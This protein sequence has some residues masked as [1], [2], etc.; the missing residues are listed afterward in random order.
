MSLNIAFEK[1][2]SM[3]ANLLWQGTQIANKNIPYRVFKP[4]WATTPLPK[5]YERS[6]PPL[7]FPRETDS[8][9]PKCVIETREKVLA[10]EM[11]LHKMV[12]EHPGEIKQRFKEVQNEIHIEKECPKHG[13]F[14][15]IMSL[16]SSF[17]KRIETLFPGRDISIQDSLHQ[18]G[19]SSIQYGRGAVLTIDLTNRCNMMCDPCFMDAN[20]VGYVHELSLEEIKKVLWSAANAHNPKRQSSVQFSGGEPT[21]SPYFIE[22]IRYAKEL[23]FFSVQAA[24]N[25][26]RFAQDKEF[27][28][29][30]AQAGLRFAYLQFDGTSPEQATGRGVGNLLEVK[31]K[32]IKNLAEF[33]VTVALV[34]T[35][36]NGVNNHQL[37]DIM[38]F[39]MENIRHIHTVAFQPVSFTGRDEDLPDEKRLQWRYTLSH[40]VK[41]L[42]AQ[43]GYL[44][45]MRDWFPLSAASPFSDLSDH[46]KGPHQDWG[47]LKCGCHPNCGI[48]S[49]VFVNMETKEQVPLSKFL[50]A[51]RVLQDVI[52]ITDYARS[53]R[54]TR[55]LVGLSLLRNWRPQHAPKGMR[56]RDIL[57][58]L[59]SHSGGSLGVSHSKRFRWGM[60][61]L[62]GMWFQDLYNYDFRRTEMCTIPYATQMGEIS[63]CAHNTGVGFRQ[64]IEK[65]YKNATVGEWYKKFGRHPIY[66]KGRQV[67][68]ETEIAEKAKEEEALVVPV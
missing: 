13:Q 60:L 36:V 15:D 62:A 6:S 5:S 41:D 30:A 46:M 3:I 23:G 66:A 19:K 65:M 47:T 11:D 1:T 45:E 4:K 57:K 32:A 63:F 35:I 49:F 29:Q 25:G 40:L 20:Q 67:P 17:T 61:T 27:C 64:I 10:G 37:G 21:L 59:D 42:K 28:R 22:A 53:P 48:A 56:F 39:T 33:G 14:R 18:H 8:L 51:D 68:L 24:T 43:T 31:R 9:C 34:V 52:Q 58:Q 54:V 16:N 2:L 44:E 12:Q 7:G 26:I 38:K 50:N 55:I